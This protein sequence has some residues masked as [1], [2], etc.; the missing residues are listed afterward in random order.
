MAVAT[1]R[2][3]RGV[4]GATLGQQRTISL[5]VPVLEGIQLLARL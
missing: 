1:L 3:I 5:I 2:E 4:Y